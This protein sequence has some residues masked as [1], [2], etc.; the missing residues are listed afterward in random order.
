LTAEPD[1]KPLAGLEVDVGV[2]DGPVAFVGDEL[3]QLATVK[4]LAA[5]TP[6]VAMR[7]VKLRRM[8]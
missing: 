3:E 5:A 2:G 4:A 6:A 1:E 7:R 8:K